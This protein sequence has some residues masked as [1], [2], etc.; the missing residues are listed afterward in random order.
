M[1]FPIL[2]SVALL[3]A[4]FGA[5]ADTLDRTD[6]AQTAID[7]LAI[8]AVAKRAGETPDAQAALAAFTNGL[9]SPE[10]R[11]LWQKSL[12]AF[13]QAPDPVAAAR[14]LGAL[15]GTL[16]QVLAL[17]MLTAYNAGDIEAARQA[18]AAIRLPKHASAVEGLLALQRINGPDDQRAEVA[19]LLSRE[20]LIWQGSR[21][22]E[23]ADE[24]LRLAK[25]DRATPELVA[26][27][28]AE[29]QALTDFPPA[30]LAAAKVAPASAGMVPAPAPSVDSIAMWKSSIEARLPDLLT[31]D[32]VTRQE[33]LVLKLLRLIPMEYRAGVRDGQIA[34]PLEY[35]EAVSFTQQAQQ[36]LV[37]VR[38]N[39]MKTKAEAMTAHGAE[40]ESLFAKLEETIAAKG[41]IATVEGA[42]KDL[43]TLLQSK[44]DVTLRK[45]GKGSDVVQETALEVRSILGQSLA[46][47]REGKWRDANALRLEAYTTFDLEIE[48]RI[49]PRDPDL[50]TRA[51]RSFLDGGHDGPGIKAV[52][53]RRAQNAELEAAYSRTLKALDE[54][55]ALLKVGLSPTTVAV[56]A[57][58]IVLREGLEAVVILA[59]LLAGLRGAENAASRRQ[60]SIGAWGAI[61][62]SA[63][64]F[65]LARTVI[66]SLSRYGETLEAVI[67]ILAVIILLIVTNWVFHKY[68]W[69]GWN[70][71]LRELKDKAATQRGQRWEALAMCGVGFLTI[72]REGFETTLFMQSLILEGGFF[73]SLTGLFIG[74]AAIGA[75][76][77]A[78]FKWGKK[79]PY[80]KLL[81]WTG[82]LVVTILATFLG[83]T[84]RLFQ[85]VGWLP[86]HPIQSLDIPPWMGTWLGLYPS[87][88]G[89]IIPML[90][91]VYVG[92]AW[93]FVRWQGLRKQATFDALLESRRATAVHPVS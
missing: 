14:A 68:Y 93:L 26:L 19:R 88:E 48:S 21:A 91:F 84:V 42:C 30:L 8:A 72:Y 25:A 39:W 75:A 12:D 81:V 31:P 53:D 60:V 16:Q 5:S 4:S 38:P 63:A 67:S 80:R 22:R 50:A 49:L 36:L 3:A 58:T 92:G 87:W 23:R 27:R 28:S 35:R 10:G 7:D 18:R 47:A 55:V 79:L 74:L 6:V 85:T 13:T 40:L 33:R 71:R 24:L 44:F 62:A 59:A 20:T 41:D 65:I 43:S 15:R 52:L 1:R 77:W 76:G 17:E 29:I 54:C 78:I 61:A 83:S 69:T 32:E 82:V 86:I 9:R 70:A 56:T 11:A 64:T 73:A 37:E 66:S 51:E 34:V 46:A 2:A 57:F 45:A 89:L 90:G